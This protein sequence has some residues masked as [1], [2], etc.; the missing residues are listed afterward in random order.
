MKPILKKN[1]KIF[2]PSFEYSS[3]SDNRDVKPF[4]FLHFSISSNGQAIVKTTV[5]DT[6]TSW[7]GSAF[8]VSLTDGLGVAEAPVKVIF[9]KCDI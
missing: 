7:L 9:N 3:V 2:P 8:A 5:P 4:K 6:I 1:L